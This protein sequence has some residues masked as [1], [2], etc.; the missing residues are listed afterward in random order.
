MKSRSGIKKKTFSFPLSWQLA[1]FGG[2]VPLVKHEPV[3]L[4]RPCV[5]RFRYQMPTRLGL[6]IH[7]WR[8]TG[9][10]DHSL[11]RSF[12]LLHSQVSQNFKEE[13]SVG[14]CAEW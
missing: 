12:S 2:K 10:D 1:L 7:L 6:D 8:I 11:L 13:A 4:R 5:M 14:V 3:H 9:L